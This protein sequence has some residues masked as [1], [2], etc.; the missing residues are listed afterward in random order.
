MFR[1]LV[2]N[3][4]D[5]NS[6]VMGTGADKYR[7]K[8]IVVME[9]LGGGNY[10]EVYRGLWKVL[11]KFMEISYIKKENYSSGIEKIKE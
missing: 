11:R 6:V 5:R 4:N 10:G 3:A 9:R 1:E 2:P 8:N 7:L